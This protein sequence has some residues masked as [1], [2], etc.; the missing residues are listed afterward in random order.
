MAA[1]DANV[2]PVK[3]AA[4]RLA[5]SFRDNAGALITGWAGATSTVSVDGASTT[6]GSA[7]VEIGSTGMGYLD[8]SASQMNGE[9]IMVKCSVSNSNS[10]PFVQAIYTGGLTEIS[11]AVPTAN[12]NASALWSMAI[13]EP[14]NMHPSTYGQV[15]VL[16]LNFLRNLFVK[17]G[18]VV[19][20]YAT[21]EGV[22]GTKL[23]QQGYSVDSTGYTR[24][25]AS[26]AI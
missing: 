17:N 1:N 24:S 5:V 26:D 8:L 13:T 10:L 3:N 25:E 21:G 14:V 12:A 15:V 9:L 16:V 7:P 6:S 2:F 22:G 19:S 20:L 11:G 18:N 4:F 23:G